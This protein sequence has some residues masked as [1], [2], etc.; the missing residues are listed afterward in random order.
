MAQ[1]NVI[2]LEDSSSTLILTEI[3]NSKEQIYN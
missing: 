1:V 3:N 2:D